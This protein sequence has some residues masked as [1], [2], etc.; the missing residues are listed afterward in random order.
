MGVVLYNCEWAQTHT[1]QKMF[2]YNVRFPAQIH[3][4]A[5]HTTI[6]SGGS[7]HML[8]GLNTDRHRHIHAAA[9]MHMVTSAL[10]DH[11]LWGN[12]N[13]PLT[14]SNC[15]GVTPLRLVNFR[16]LSR[17]NAAIPEGCQ[18]PAFLA[19]L[20][21]CSLSSRCLNVNIPGP[22]TSL[23]SDGDSAGAP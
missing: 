13:C 8:S 11:F 2:L 6:F 10:H 4:S 17:C 7:V 3:S 9:C 18:N 21:L 5:A 14:F 23:S 15:R 22:F 12:S 16:G 19:P 20:T 1:Q